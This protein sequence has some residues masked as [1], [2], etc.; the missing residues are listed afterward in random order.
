M[1]HIANFVLGLSLLCGVS[2]TSYADDQPIKLGALFA[3][4]GWA[5]TGGKPELNA[6]LLAID[7]INASGGIAGHKIQLI[8]EDI[9]SDFP[10]TIS[11]FNKLASLDKVVAIFG[12]NW[13]EFGE[14]V[15]PLAERNKV[16]TLMA[17]PYS[18]SF[19]EKHSY[20]FTATPEFE[21]HVHNLTEHINKQHHNRV[22]L[23]Y[24]PSPY[25]E[26]LSQ[27]AVD[28]LK[29]PGAH[30]LP[31]IEVLPN[32]TDFKSI[33]ARLQ[34]SKVDAVIAFLQEGAA[35]SSFFRAA[36]GLKFNSQIYSYDISFD[37]TIHKEPGLA[38]G[39]IFFRYS[40]A[41]DPKFESSYATRFKE[42]SSYSAPFAYDLMYLFKQ[43]FE[44]C[45]GDLPKLNQC[46]SSTE[47]HGVSGT[48]RFGATGV[49]TG[50]KSMTQLYRVRNGKF[51]ALAESAQ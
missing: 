50:I 5:A 14:I 4:S 3:T 11:A 34:S 42:A 12:P 19:S 30:I 31:P 13:A 18:P 10:T 47:H 29:A 49:N 22:A 45:K 48:I 7:E 51:I 6:L 33:V 41:I 9:R 1:K 21:V 27:A 36:R 46:I 23:V 32:E 16:P 15:I 8:T 37:E 44:N 39:T 35:V 25:F 38:E 24:S 43:A 17:S 20:I 40:M 26:G 28:N 2:F